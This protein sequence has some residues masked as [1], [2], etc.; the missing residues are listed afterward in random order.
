MSQL[1]T[2]PPSPAW[3]S[4]SPRGADDQSHA[5]QLVSATGDQPEVLSLPSN[6]NN[7]LT[8]VTNNTR[9]CWTH[10]VF[11]RPPLGVGHH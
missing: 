1:Q 7:T 6:H 11:T 5:T 4:E 10:P 9:S 3:Q 8:A 2:P